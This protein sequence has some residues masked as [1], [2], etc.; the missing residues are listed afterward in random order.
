MQQPEI[1]ED[2]SNNGGN[3]IL[4]RPDID[5]LCQISIQMGLS[6]DISGSIIV[7]ATHRRSYTTDA[8]AIR[9]RRSRLIYQTRRYRI[10]RQIKITNLSV[11]LILTVQRSTS[12]LVYQLIQ[13]TTEQVGQLY[14]NR[15]IPRRIGHSRQIILSLTTI[16]K[17]IGSDHPTPTPLLC[18]IT[19][20]RLESSISTPQVVLVRII[21]V[22]SGRHYIYNAYSLISLI[23]STI[24]C[25]LREQYR[26][27]IAIE[28]VHSGRYYRCNMHYQISYNRLISR[29]QIQQ[30]DNTI[31]DNDSQRD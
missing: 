22:C 5:E 23:S 3:N 4:T 20:F 24:V 2:S 21:A 19:V 18:R 12:Y 31:I 8:T 16:Y 10:A 28:T 30:V 17:V 13:T 1:E 7:I 11:L 26:R 25:S 29:R 14:R 27:S 9:R 15:L 6:T